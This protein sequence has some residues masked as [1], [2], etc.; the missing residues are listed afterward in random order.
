MGR[1]MVLVQEGSVFYACTKFE[2]DIYIPSKVIRGSQN[3][4]IGSLDPEQA[5]LGVVLW[6]S[7][8]RGPSSMS[9]PNLKRIALFIQKL[10]GLS[11]NFE[12]WSRD[13]GHAQLWVALWS[14]RSKVSSSMSV[15]NLKRIA[16]FVQKL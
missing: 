5:H 9:L 16:L 4:E 8:R 14:G 12:I 15:P 7:R 13:L 11:Q 2:V 3:F 6:S 10:L 1:F